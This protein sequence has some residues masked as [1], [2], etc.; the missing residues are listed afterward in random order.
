MTCSVD[1][2]VEQD[3]RGYGGHP[4][5]QVVTVHRELACYAWIGR[6]QDSV[7]EN[8]RASIT[9][10]RLMCDPTADLRE[11]DL[12][13]LVRNYGGQGNLP[14]TRQMQ[15]K[16]IVPQPLQLTATLEVAA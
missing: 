9:V 6:D 13:T 16:A 10:I 3:R 7:T 1:R 4:V 12:V 15:V 14:E 8:R 2:A 11:G 5:R